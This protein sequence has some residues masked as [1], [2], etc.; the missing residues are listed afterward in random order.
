M[1]ITSSLL[2]I[3]KH[4]KK[5][6]GNCRTILSYY[7]EPVMVHFTLMQKNIWELTKEEQMPLQNF[8]FQVLILLL[9]NG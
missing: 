4:G 7:S 8:I 6:M 2:Q 1:P 3:L 9:L 5:Q